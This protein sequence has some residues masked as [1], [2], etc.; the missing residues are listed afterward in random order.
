M[1]IKIAIALSLI[2]AGELYIVIAIF[3]KGLFFPGLIALEALV[4]GVAWLAL[5]AKDFIDQTQQ[6]KRR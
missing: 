4:I 2:A 5:L 1:K 3:P 6:T